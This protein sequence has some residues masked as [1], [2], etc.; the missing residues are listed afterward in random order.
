MICELRENN[1]WFRIEYYSCNKSNGVGDD[2]FV[3]DV[4]PER[5]VFITRFR[6]P[7]CFL[8]SNLD[9]LQREVVDIARQYDDCKGEKDEDQSQP[10]D[11]LG[12]ILQFLTIPRFHSPLSPIIQIHHE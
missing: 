12:P 1:V 4:Q 8:H 3:R 9:V 5:E 11:S 10:L 7:V 6:T 2:T